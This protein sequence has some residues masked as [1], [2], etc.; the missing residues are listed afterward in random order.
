MLELRALRLHVERSGWSCTLRSLAIR[1]SNGKETNRVTSPQTGTGWTC[2]CC[3][4]AHE[5]YA[6]SFGSPA[7]LPWMMATDTERSAGEINADSCILHDR[8]G[9]QYFLRALLEIPVHDADDSFSWGVWVSLSEKD[10]N[11]QAR[12]WVD[13]ER[14]QLAPMFAW[15]CTDLPC[16]EET[17]LSLPTTL[18]TRGPGITP[19]IRLEPSGRHRLALEQAQGISLHRVAEINAAL[20]G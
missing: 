13:P 10:M 7:P 5:E 4:A 12:N 3:G 15:L 6:M 1:R 2:S 18:H 16:Y 17:T 9:T 20:L 14:A 19:L 8:D 11:T